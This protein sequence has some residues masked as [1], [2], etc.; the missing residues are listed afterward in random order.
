MFYVETAERDSLHVVTNTIEGS[1]GFIKARISKKPSM[2]FC[3]I[4]QFEGNSYY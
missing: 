2:L 1:V 4:I 3:R